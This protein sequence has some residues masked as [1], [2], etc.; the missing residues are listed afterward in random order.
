M[1]GI[2][3][4]DLLAVLTPQEKSDFQRFVV[5]PFFNEGPSVK[6]EALLLAYLLKEQKGD[7]QQEE[8]F[9]RLVAY[10]AVFPGQRFVEKKL[11]K[12]LSNLHALLKHFIA[13][14][15]REAEQFENEI[16]Q[17]RFFRE[18]GLHNR[19]ENQSRNLSAMIEQSMYSRA[20]IKHRF[21]LKYELCQY[22]SLFN[23][24]KAHQIIP[25]V[26][27]DLEADYLNAKLELLNQYLLSQK[28]VL[29]DMPEDM[30][31]LL[32]QHYIPETLLVKY[33]NLLLSHKISNLFTPELPGVDSFVELQTLLQKYEPYIDPVEVQIFAVYLRNLCFLLVI[34]NHSEY[35]PVLFNLQKDHYQRGYLSHEGKISPYALLGASNTA[36]MVGELEWC[37]QFLAETEHNILGE[38]PEKHYFNLCKA[39]LL[40]YQKQYQQALDILPLNFSNTEYLLFSRRLE[41][42]CYYELA[43]DLL[44]YKMDAFKMYLSRASKTLIAESVRERNANFLNMLIQINKYSG[45]KS[46]E[47]VQ[48]LLARIEAKTQITDREW[49]VEKAASL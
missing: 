44:D 20:K 15:Y 23:N 10:E 4:G 16:A 39:N 33:P 17:L 45:L 28:R 22:E 37:A 12:L 6:E 11:E 21:L 42:K 48:K 2:R 13:I 31:R 8:G 49:L 27:E 29:F 36:L 30:L 14:K 1:T 7:G 35:L 24:K 43:S 34:N 3:L 47:H 46:K 32:H 41:I 9:D 18:R 40:F 19:Y 5:S 38:T 25:E 26:L